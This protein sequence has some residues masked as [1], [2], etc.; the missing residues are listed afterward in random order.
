MCPSFCVY[1]LAR[2]IFALC[3]WQLLR[4]RSQQ[5]HYIMYIRARCGEDRWRKERW[6]WRRAWAAVLL[7]FLFLFWLLSHPTCPFSRVS[8]VLPRLWRRFRWW[9]F[10]FCRLDPRR[11]PASVGVACLSLVEF[12]FIFRSWHLLCPSPTPLPWSPLHLISAV[13]TLLPRWPAMM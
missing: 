4:L 13:I 3:P 12:I 7:L 11:P 8:A 9:E 5:L 6:R 1:P 10:M 2:S